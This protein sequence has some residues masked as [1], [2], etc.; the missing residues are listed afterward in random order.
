M[1]L[2]DHSAVRPTIA[3]EALKEQL[4]RQH[5][6]PIRWAA[7]GI[8]TAR[9]TLP[10]TMRIFAGFLC[11]AGACWM[12]YDYWVRHADLWDVSLFMAIALA[13]GTL[14]AFIDG[15]RLHQAPKKT[16]YGASEEKFFCILPDGTVTAKRWTNMEGHNLFAREDGSLHLSYLGQVAS[17]GSTTTQRIAFDDIEGD[18]ETVAFLN[19]LRQQALDRHAQ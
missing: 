5:K 14:L 15:L 10:I 6:G 17:G 2:D 11:W 1:L 4:P 18:R 9:L 7:P 13:G 3:A 16:L 12:G 19:Q 8:R